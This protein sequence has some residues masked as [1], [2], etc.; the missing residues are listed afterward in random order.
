MNK[1]YWF[2]DMSRVASGFLGSLS[3]FRQEL[4]IWVQ[5]CVERLL[6]RINYVKRE[7]FE[8][9]KA[10]V[11]QARADQEMLKERLDKLEKTNFK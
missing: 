7:E 8:V 2:E 1:N 10:M 11:A 5:D 9:V 4:E 6:M 3:S